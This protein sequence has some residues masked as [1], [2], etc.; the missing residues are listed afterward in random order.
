MVAM[1]T[2]GIG[3]VVLL[4]FIVYILPVQVLALGS[5][6]VASEVPVNNKV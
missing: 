6:T 4:F 2:T 5:V 1:V 3:V